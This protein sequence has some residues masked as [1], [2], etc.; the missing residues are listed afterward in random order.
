MTA[1]TK[2]AVAFLEQ[3]KLDRKVLL[4]TS[5]KTPELMRSTNNL[6]NVLVVKAMYLNVY[7]ILNADH[8]VI[9]DKALPIIETWLTGGEA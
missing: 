6:Q 8:I 5:D 1:K 4:V 9:S 7:H 3:Q 2:D